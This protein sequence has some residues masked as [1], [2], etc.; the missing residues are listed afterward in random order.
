[1]DGYKGLG[2]IVENNMADIFGFVPHAG[3]LDFFIQHVLF[4][5]AEKYFQL[6]SAVSLAAHKCHFLSIL[7]YP[8]IALLLLY[9]GKVNEKKKLAQ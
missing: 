9:C 8:A 7:P 3:C 5:I 6:M 4:I 1:M 2:I